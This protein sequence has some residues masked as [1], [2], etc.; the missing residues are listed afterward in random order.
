[1]ASFLG[2]A[3]LALL[4]RNYT[5]ILPPSRRW[6]HKGD[7]KA[8][9]WEGLKFQCCEVFVGEWVIQAHAINVY[10]SILEGKLAAE[11]ESIF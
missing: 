2:V 6:S 11:V 1:M 3:V 10:Y 5:G 9:E 4:A 7:D 8:K